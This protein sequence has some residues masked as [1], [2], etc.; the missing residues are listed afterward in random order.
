MKNLLFI[1][2]FAVCLLAACSSSAAPQPA[3]QPP[4]QPAAPVDT[5]TPRP[6]VQV[7]SNIPV[8]DSATDL[9]VT[10]SNISYVVKGSLK[11][12]MAYF[13]KEM[14]ARG[15]KEQEPASVI[16]DFGRMYYED[17]THQVSI[18]LNASPTIN[19]VVVQMTLMTLNVVEGT[20]TP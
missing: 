4:S 17:P 10:Q 3:S 18:L 11:D 12:V 15:W 19:Q 5:P 6:Q 2:L 7:P 14:T 1:L 16:T 20:P 9:K 13:D 8:M